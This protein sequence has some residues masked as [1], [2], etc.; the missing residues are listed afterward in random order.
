[1]PKYQ[2]GDRVEGA[3]NGLPATVTEVTPKGTYWVKWDNSGLSE[4]EELEGDLD[5]I[6]TWKKF[7]D[8]RER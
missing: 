5:P 8:S 1:V 4:T 6:G 2:V 3:I 7:L